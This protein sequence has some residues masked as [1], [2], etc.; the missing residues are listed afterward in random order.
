MR[1][2]FRVAM[3]KTIVFL[4]VDN[5]ISTEFS[6]DLEARRRLIDYGRERTRQFLRQWAY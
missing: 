2:T 1:A 3:K 5:V 4:P 6:I